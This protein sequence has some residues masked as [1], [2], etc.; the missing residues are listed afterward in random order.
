[1]RGPKELKKAPVEELDRVAGTSYEKIETGPIRTCA[2]CKSKRLQS[3]LIRVV[4]AP[5]GAVTVDTGPRGKTPGRGAYVCPDRACIERALRG[6]LGRVLKHGGTLPE[7]L[8]DELLAM[9]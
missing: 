4:L 8:E 2:G 7:A 3:E 1:L 9:V 5:G 6:G